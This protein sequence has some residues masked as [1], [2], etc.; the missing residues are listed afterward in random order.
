MTPE[1]AAW[2]RRDLAVACATCRAVPGQPCRGRHHLPHPARLR[3]AIF[4][5]AR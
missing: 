1:A 4:G 2:R 5:G 3:A